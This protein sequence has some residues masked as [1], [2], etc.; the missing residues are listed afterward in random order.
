M[1]KVYMV[2]LF[3]IVFVIT[4]CTFKPT[5]INKDSTGDIQE[6]T[7]IENTWTNMEMEEFTWEFDSWVVGDVDTLIE[8]RN[9]Q[10]KDDTKLTEEDITLMEE[11]ITKIQDIWK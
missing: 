5:S 7:W 11:I 6:L 8:E 4:G 2:G 10:P 3:L 9:T 1:K